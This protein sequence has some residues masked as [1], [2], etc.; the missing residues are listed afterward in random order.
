MPIN[1]REAKSNEAFYPLMTVPIKKVSFTHEALA[2]WLIENPHQNYKAAGLFFGY[3]PTY[4][5]CIV[6]SDAFQEFYRKKF[7]EHH[8]ILGL[9]IRGK[10]GVATDLAL[11]GL[12][13]KL[14]TTEDAGF[15]L[16]ATDKLLN[17]MGYAPSSQRVMGSVNIDAST[18][19]TTVVVS[20][21]QLAGARQL[22]LSQGKPKE[23]VEQSGNSQEAIGR[24]IEGQLAGESE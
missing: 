18:K 8:V 24:L 7:Q 14:E 11:E 5:G 4:I 10:L 16:D 1:L 17:R 12:T 13:R 20:R 19:N 6:R 21:D 3:T 15:L 22:L 2:L 23:V 9:D